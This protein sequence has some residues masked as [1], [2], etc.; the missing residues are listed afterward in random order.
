MTALSF[1]EITAKRFMRTM[2]PVRRNS[3]DVDDKRAKVF[4][5]IADGTVAGALS[6]IDKALSAIREWDNHVKEAGK[7]HRLGA[8]AIRLYEVLLRRC[9]DF[10][11]GRCEPCLDTLQRLMGLARATI[12]SYLARLK[13]EGFLG[14]QRRTKKTGNAPGEGPQVRQISNAYYF[15]TERWPV[16]ALR[17]LKDRLQRATARM[18][19]VANG[20]SSI[21]QAAADRAIER[22]GLAA[23]TRATG[24]ADP[25]MVEQLA[26]FAERFDAES[27]SSQSSLN[28]PPRIKY[29][30]SESG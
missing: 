12:V 2:Q 6:F 5:P 11:T 24:T 22:I 18:R 27:A 14:W 29:K 26:R 4:R 21:V 28:P 13:E 30:R 15:G 19:K 8:G 17:G 10:K 1:G 23:Y 7:R 9:T 3:Y 25:E 20:V 16:G